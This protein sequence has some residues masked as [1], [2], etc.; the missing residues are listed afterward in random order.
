MLQQDII[1]VKV[2]FTDYSGEKLRPAL[3]V[4]NTDYNSRNH[5]VVICGITSNL[6]KIPYSVFIS[7]D[8][9]SQGQLPLSSKIRADKIMQIEKSR[10]VKK[11]ARLNDQTF[12][13]VVKEIIKLVSTAA[14]S[15]A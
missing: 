2:P 11:F 4:S 5:D 12:E 9:L 15:R 8:N 10:I 3:V 7:Q 13:L 6:D 14:P 1:L